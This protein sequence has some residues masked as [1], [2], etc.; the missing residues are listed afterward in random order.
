MN[1]SA[2]KTPEHAKGREIILRLYEIEGKSGECKITFA[3]RPVSAKVTDILERTQAD[4]AVSGNIIT[5]FVHANE[6]VTLRV[7]F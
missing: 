3:D 2:V 1:V 6:V 7:K 4:T 5:V